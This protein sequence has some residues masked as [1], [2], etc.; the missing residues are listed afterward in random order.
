MSVAWR[1]VVQYSLDVHKKARTFHD[2]SLEYHPASQRVVLY[3]AESS[4]VDAMQPVRA[5]MLCAEGELT[6][7]KTFVRVLG[8]AQEEKAA[9][10]AARGN[11]RTSSTD[12]P[13]SMHGT[14]QH[15]VLYT[16]DKHK[17]AKKWHDGWM[18]LQS[19]GLALFYNDGDDR[20]VHR[21]QVKSMQE[22]EEGTILETS[23]LLIEI[24]SKIAEL[25]TPRKATSPS[26]NEEEEQ[27][28]ID[29][30]A[31]ASTLGP[32][33]AEQEYELLYTA[34][35]VKKLKRWKDG[36]LKW[37]PT[38]LSLFYNEEGRV[39]HR[40][41]V[42]THELAEGHELAS[43]QYL[44]Q[45]GAAIRALFPDSEQSQSQ[46]HPQ[47][48][49]KP[50]LLDAPRKRPRIGNRETAEPVTKKSPRLKPSISRTSISQTREAFILMLMMM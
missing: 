9:N 4:V 49:P 6:L 27:E 10:K 31:N 21:R 35:K 50:K 5:T 38:G 43:A 8:S 40:R 17:K 23:T 24:T 26:H 46:P 42:E 13:L 14:C 11:S 37:S 19:S 25:R 45:I 3:D 39:M 29:Q 18:S 7:E 28:R 16:S 20:I 22:I 48:Q 47:P 1:F 32:Q 41:R 12:G 2:G 34:D 33:D 44:F 36:R 15:Q 30:P